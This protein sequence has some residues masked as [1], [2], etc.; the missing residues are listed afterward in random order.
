MLCISDNHRRKSG[1]ID[2]EE[3]IYKYI[4]TD[5]LICIAHFKTAKR[6]LF[7]KYSV[8]PDVL[9]VHVGLKLDCI[10]VNVMW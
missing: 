2:Q 5:R 4:L 1:D 8:N 10:I 7:T 6:L 3:E 9:K